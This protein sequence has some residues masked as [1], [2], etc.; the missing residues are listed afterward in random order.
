MT[1]QRCPLLLHELP[2][3]PGLLLPPLHSFLATV[4]P[5]M[6]YLL[7]GCGVTTSPYLAQVLA[8][9]ICLKCAD[10]EEKGSLGRMQTLIYKLYSLASCEKVI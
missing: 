2:S 9:Y 3:F 7:R 5:M 1:D 10:V 4:V 6:T 8:S